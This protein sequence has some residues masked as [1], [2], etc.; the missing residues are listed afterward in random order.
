MNNNNILTYNN[1]CSGC[2]ACVSV[3]SKNAIRVALNS[4]GFY[5]AFVDETL[6]VDCGFCK[7][8]CIRDQAITGT[9]IRTGVVFAAQSKDP[10]TIKKCTSGGISYEL[11]KQAFSDGMGVLGVVY[12]Y[13]TNKAKS[14]IART[15]DDLDKITGSK[16]IQSYTVDGFKALLA[17]MK[18]NT[19]RKYI[20]FGTPCQMYGLASILEYFGLR[21]RAILVEMF[22]HGVPS[23]LVW[24]SYLD[25]LRPIVGKGVLEKVTFRD[26]KTGW[27]NYVMTVKGVDGTYRENSEGDLFYKAYFDNVFFSKACFDCKVR[28]ELSKADLR[29]GDC[30]GKRYQD[31]EEGISAILV[32]SERGMRFID[33]L[34]ERINIL[35]ELNVSE[36]LSGQSLSSYW[37]SALNT[38]AIDSLKSGN[39]IKSTIKTYRKEFPFKRRVKFALREATAFLPDC[40]RATIRKIYRKI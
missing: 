38:N 24:D 8:V 15:T 18:G 12:D 20:A 26:K 5:S 14:I 16:Y 10:L 13:E 40:L 3:C 11:S 1:P 17:D 33:S 32:L 21:E 36:V 29:L 7:K 6:C 9:L 28:C 37:E 39:D 27:H 35:Q 34:E 25:A 2:G 4:E 22:C 30:W 19:E 23:Y 31:N